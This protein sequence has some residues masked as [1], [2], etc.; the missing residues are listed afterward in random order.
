MMQER[1]MEAL[2]LG[3][4]RVV[5]WADILDG[6]NVFPVPDG[7]TGRNLVISLAPFKLKTYALPDI[8]RALLM[9]ARGNSGNIVARFMSGF[10]AMDN[11]SDLAIPCRRGRDLAYQ[12][13][14]DPKPG[15]ILEFF[16]VLVESLEKNPQ[17]SEGLWLDKVMGDLEEAVKRTSTG[18]EEIKKAGVV[19]AGALG[20]FVFFD[21]S[22]KYLA[23]R[24]TIPNGLG[25]KFKNFLKPVVFTGK[26]TEGFC[27]DAIIERKMLKDDPAQL[28]ALGESIVMIEDG[29]YL[30][31]HFHADNTKEARKQLGEMGNI[32]SWAQ[33]D[34]GEQARLFAR[35]GHRQAIHIMTDAAGSMTRND[36][37]ELNVTLLDSYITVGDLCLPET[38]HDPLHMLESMRQGVK[39]STSQASAFE[40]HHHYHKVLSLYPRVL[41]LCV[42]SVYTGNYEVVMDWKKDNDPEDRLTV[43]DTG[44]ASGRLGLVAR[45]V[46]EFSLKANDPD[47]VIRYAGQ[48]VGECEEYIFL[49]KL[50]YLAAGG[51]MSKTGAFFGDMLH[52]KPIVSPTPSGAVKVGTARNAKDQKAFVDRK[53]EPFMAHHP[54]AVI[55]LEYT[56]NIDWVMEQ[57]ET[58]IRKRYPQARIILQ[59]I[60]LTSSVHMGPGTWA[61]AFLPNKP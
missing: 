14:H 17:D 38:Y 35:G 46:A 48:A 21:S 22:L 31:V 5:A 54:D 30:K 11:L 44:L 53:L 50:Q 56:D 1:L 28:S 45:A 24:E 39:A 18:L 47:E 55:M 27:V 40:R 7:D 26:Q 10:L 49:D 41:Y 61:I 32:V 52:V 43:I 4:E 59:P 3:S 34:M 51:R 9:N 2:A 20:M 19:D 42:G 58:P 37:R 6:I 33:D 60:S 25:E 12:A 16:D 13:V 36:A 57:V 23:G 15:T 29:D 8:T